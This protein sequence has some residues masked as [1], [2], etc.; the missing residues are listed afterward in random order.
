MPEPP[1]SVLLPVFNAAEFLSAAIDS[2]TAQSLADIQIVII[3][4]GSTDGSTDI[5]KDYARQ[6][7]RIEV[8]QRP[9]RGLV[10]TLNEGIDLCHGE[11]IA[12]MDADDISLPQRLEKQL[13]HMRSHPQTVAMGTAIEYLATR[14][15]TGVN[16]RQ[17]TDADTILNLLPRKN[18]I[19]HPTVMMRKSSVQAVG[20]YRGVYLHAE[21]YDLWLQLA[22]CGDL[23]NLPEP[24]VQYRVHSDQISARHLRIQALSI[25]A[26]RLGT[27]PE[28]LPAAIGDR[29]ILEN[30]A[31]YVSLLVRIGEI[32]AAR[33]VLARDELFK[34]ATIT[35]RSAARRRMLTARVHWATHR[36]VSAIAAATMG[37]LW[38]P[39]LAVE[40][41]G[42]L[43]R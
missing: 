21:D 4:D 37:T 10:A 13:H 24:L 1:V 23:E 34:L 9:N 41:I 42:R 12:R 14:G 15:P 19:S 2:I 32:D 11:F 16:S 6:D 33:E 30:A 20:G 43:L 36:P 25:A 35:R 8:H 22:R 29:A 27:K 5:L 28:L 17:P 38:D 40:L 31:G 3:N 18:C 26:A 39:A 7:S